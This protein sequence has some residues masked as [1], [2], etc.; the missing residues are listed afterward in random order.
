MYMYM[1]HVYALLFKFSESV[2][3]VNFCFEIY[4][5]FILSDIYLMGSDSLLWSFNFVFLH[6]RLRYCYVLLYHVISF[7]MFIMNL[8]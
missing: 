2:K 6:A 8:F 4:E 1:H 7:I 5:A 3:C